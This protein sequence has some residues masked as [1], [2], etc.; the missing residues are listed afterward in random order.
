MALRPRF[1]AG[2]LFRGCKLKPYA[3]GEAEQTCSST[4]TCGANGERS[5]A[6]VLFGMQLIIGHR[7]VESE[8]LAAAD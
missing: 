5:S 2:L 3:A 1:T 7:I 4:S 8:Q 6:G